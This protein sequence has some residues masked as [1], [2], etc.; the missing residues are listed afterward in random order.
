M[1]HIIIIGGGIAGIYT[2]YQITK[3]FKNT[4]FL[5]IEGSNRFGGRV[6]TI[7]QLEAGAGRFSH[8]HKY[9]MELIDELGLK[10]KLNLATAKAEYFPINKSTNPITE[11]PTLF[12]KL[13]E[14]Y[15]KKNTKSFNRI[16]CQSSSF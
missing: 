4:N 10:N 15:L 9:L 16:N 3:Q 1:K 5:V 12:S 11:S 6:H 7:N 14:W 2:A 8:N 13:L